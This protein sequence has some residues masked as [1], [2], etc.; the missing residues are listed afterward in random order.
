MRL[1]R[2]R[3]A[4]ILAAAQPVFWIFDEQAVYQARLVALRVQRDENA[5]IRT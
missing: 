4:A 5:Y 2:V 1:H 3:A